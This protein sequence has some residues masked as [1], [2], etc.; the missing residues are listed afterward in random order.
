MNRLLLDDD[1][2][3]VCKSRCNRNLCSRNLY[4]YWKE[5]LYNKVLVNDDL[6]I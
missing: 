2:E 6:C 1:F 4:S 5:L 3:I